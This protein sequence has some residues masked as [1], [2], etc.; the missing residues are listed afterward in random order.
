MLSC[1]ATIHCPYC[2]EQIEVPPEYSHLAFKVNP[3]N[4]SVWFLCPNCRQ[5]SFL[6]P[7]EVTNED[8][9]R[10]RDAIAQFMESYLEIPLDL[11]RLK[12]KVKKALPE[13]LRPKFREV[14]VDPHGALHFLFDE[15][16]VVMG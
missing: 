6:Y 7:G 16:E 2:E 14:A 8:L 10:A 5:A 4:L 15:F 1:M 9:R 11:K 3:H 13:D 12:K